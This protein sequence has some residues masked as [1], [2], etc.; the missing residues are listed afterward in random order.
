MPGSTS[1]GYPYPL[2]GDPVDVAGDIQR[3]AEALDVSSPNPSPVGIIMAYAGQT[4]PSADWLLCNGALI[5]A[6]SSY[7]A[8]RALVGTTTPDL[9]NRFILGS[10]TRANGTTGGVEQ[11]T[12]N[13]NQMPN[14]SHGASAGN[15]TA[16]HSHQGNTG[17]S[18]QHAHTNNPGANGQANAFALTAAGAPAQELWAGAGTFQYYMTYSNQTAEA[19]LHEHYVVTGGRSTPHQHIITVSS[20]GGGAPHE[21]MP[22]F[23]VLTYIVRARL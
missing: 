21:N 15:E 7:D 22:P 8:L 1:R 18:G 9:R 11:V 2:D 3:L 16:D 14:H 13:Q 10:G 6:D 12:L 4:A 19:G 20:A 23:Y 17:W 5:P